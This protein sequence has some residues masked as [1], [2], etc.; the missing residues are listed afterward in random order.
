MSP[1]NLAPKRSSAT[2][3]ITANRGIDEMP[4]PPSLAAAARC[5]AKTRS[6]R[7]CQAPAMKNGRCRMHGGPSTGAPRGSQNALKHG[8]YARDVVEMRRQLRRFRH[9]LRSFDD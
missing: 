9:N 4:Q 5:L 7:P 2:S 8:L 3:I 1:S 6:G